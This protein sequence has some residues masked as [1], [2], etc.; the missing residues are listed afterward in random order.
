M[1]TTFSRTFFP[2]AI[3]LL[4]ALLLVGL[5][6]QMLVKDYLTKQT[7]ASLKNDGECIAELV[8][9]YGAEEYMTGRDFH[10]ALSTASRVSGADAVICDATGR[11]VL[12]AEAPL[13]CEHTGLV[14]EKSYLDKTFAENGCSST[15]IIGGLYEDTRSYKPCGMTGCMQDGSNKSFFPHGFHQFI[16]AETLVNRDCDYDALLDDSFSVLFG[17]DYKQVLDYL[18]GVSEAFGEKYMAGEERAKDARDPLHNPARAV[19]L[20]QDLR[21]E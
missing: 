15:G 13:G 12:C 18:N 5:S 4:T 11:L 20:E 21:T 6:F 19:K 7:M 14:L 16:H 17:G 2:S 9:A 3:I 1:K 8:L 10:I